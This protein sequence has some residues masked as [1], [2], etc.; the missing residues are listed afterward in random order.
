MATEGKKM[1]DA[2]V[3]PKRNLARQESEAI[4]DSDDGKNGRDAGNLPGSFQMA[5]SKFS[6]YKDGAK[7]KGPPAELLK[8]H[9]RD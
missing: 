7:P 1:A 4:G 2:V 9:A 6:G 5:Q 8:K 3:N